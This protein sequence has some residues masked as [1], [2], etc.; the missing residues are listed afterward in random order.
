MSHDEEVDTLVIGGGIAGLAYAHGRGAGSDVVVIDAADH[1][2]GLMRTHRIEGLQVDGQ[3]EAPFH[4]EAGPEALQNNAPEVR[5]FFDELSLDV[6]EADEAARHR[7]LLHPD[8]EL[9]ELPTSPTSFLSTRLISW[10]GKIRVLSEPFRKK[11]VA[12]DGSIADFVR[13][14]LGEEVLRTFVDPGISG[15]YAGMPDQLSLKGTFPRLHELAAD[16]G[17][18][19]AAMKA[20][21]RASSGKPKQALS[22]LSV[23]GGMQSVPEAVQ[24]SLGDRL[25]LATRAMSLERDGDRWRVAAKTSAGEM[26]RVARRVVVALPV[27]PAATLLEKVSPAISQELASMVSETVVSVAHL[28]RRE[29]IGHDLGGFG[30]LV[31]SILG[32]MHLGTLFSSS[33][34]P[35]RC[36]PDRV[37]LRTMLGGARRPGQAD[38]DDDELVELVCNE[39]AA[40]L[41]IREGAKPLW[42]RIDRWCQAL[43]RYDLDQPVRQDRIDSLLAELPRLDVIGNHRRG[44]AV[45]ALITSSR[46]LARAHTEGA[47]A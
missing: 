20:K 5:A 8:N 32:R 28:W 3:D 12:L 24:T 10:P 36:A 19:F 1:V 39:V 29:D 47:R 41:K 44:V 2:G 26:T 35:E 17:S 14:R 31:P 40:P 21:R 18:I 16:H 33:I 30:Y 4:V 42:T 22:L 38:L 43:P 23:R 27:Q 7:F 6:V 15:I 13:H 9:D 25:K 46:E 11:G 37:V 45:N 34:I